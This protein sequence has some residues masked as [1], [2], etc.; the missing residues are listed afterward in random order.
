MSKKKL[1]DKKKNI[2]I[3]VIVVALFIIVGIATSFGVIYL[4]K[5][6]KGASEETSKVSENVTDNDETNGSKVEE[7]EKEKQDEEDSEEENEKEDN[8]EETVPS[9]GNNQS[10]VATP[11]TNNAASVQILKDAINSTPLN[12]IIT[13]YDKVDSQVGAII[14]SIITPGMSNYDKL[15][16][17]YNYMIQN[18]VYYTGDIEYSIN[19]MKREVG[20]LHY[21][22][23]DMLLLFQ[24][25]DVL[26][27]KSGVCFNYSALLLTLGRRVGFD[28]YTVN[29]IN[30]EGGAHT[31]NVVQAG[32]N[33]YI[34]DSQG[35]DGGSASLNY[36][37][38]KPLSE[39]ASLYKAVYGIN[40]FYGFAE[41]PNYYEHSAIMSIGD[42][43]VKSSADTIL[44]DGSNLG[45]YTI[46]VNKGA[47]IRT[48]D[49][50]ISDYGLISSFT[51]KKPDGTLDSFSY[52][53]E[54]I[55]GRTL[56]YTFRQVGD[57]YITFE[58]S[59]SS[60]GEYGI[61]GFIVHVVE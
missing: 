58:L 6:N 8:E 31:F 7:E 43:T 51:L 49:D 14:N 57:Y 28:I 5:H 42:V 37:F 4:A 27:N 24:G 35:D 56:G 46:Q 3:A 29:A 9:T 60:T 25:L 38:G 32:G 44:E 1:S 53:N 54:A 30:N 39:G 59:D 55:V 11:S 12:P 48:D 18:T 10:T 17:I 2:L 50:R 19:N 23:S 47:T 40:S 26:E 52:T 45:E 34:L 33:Y 21:Y 16:A 61:V 15:V 22:Y 41:D 13:R 20:Y 36:F